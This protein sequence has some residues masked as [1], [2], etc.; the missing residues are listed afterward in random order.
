MKET[1]QISFRIEMTGFYEN[2]AGR[3]IIATS[4]LPTRHHCSHVGRG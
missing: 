3:A 1:L 4:W 2:V